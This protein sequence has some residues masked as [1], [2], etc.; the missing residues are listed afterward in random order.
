[1][2]D[3]GRHQTDLEQQPFPS[4]PWP[5]AAGH[6]RWTEPALNSTKAHGEYTGADDGVQCAT[7]RR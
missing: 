1:M 6:R 7:A 3:R 5:S 4:G 2:A